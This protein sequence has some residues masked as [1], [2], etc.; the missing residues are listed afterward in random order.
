VIKLAGEV[1]N[2]KA[3]IDKYLIW[4]KDVHKAFDEEVEFLDNN[5]TFICDQP[6][7]YEVL[8]LTKDKKLECEYT[9]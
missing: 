7:I 6:N 5:P 1:I 3:L 9:Y 8:G 4:L 2:S